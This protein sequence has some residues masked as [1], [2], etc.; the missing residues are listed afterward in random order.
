MIRPGPLVL[1]YHGIAEVPAATDP[2][3][4]FVPP[5]AFRAQLVA[6]RNAGFQPLDLDG[7]LAAQADP[8]PQAARQVLI[9]LD[10]G[11]VS[12]LQEAAPALEEQ[13]FP[14]LCFVSAGLLGHTVHGQPHPAYDLLDADQVRSLPEHGIEVG[15][16]G[17][18]HLA[19][20]EVP[21]GQLHKHTDDARAV[22]TDL[23]GS[24]P[25]TFAYPYGD[26][27]ERVRDAVQN[28]GYDI[29]FATHDGAGPMAVTRVDVNSTDTPRSFGLKLRRWYPTARRTL[30]TVGPVRSFAHRLIGSADRSIPADGQH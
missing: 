19:M 3:N 17:W 23:V 18:D 1:M 29:G 14:A 8:S 27:D 22:L 7:Y 28:A 21:T 11:Y 12:T 10:D 30:G 13:G 24:R 5:Q 2:H 16:H 9:T 4:L 26:H 6:L 15:V 25:A 20:T